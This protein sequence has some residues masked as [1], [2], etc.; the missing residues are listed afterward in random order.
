[1]RLRD[2][3]PVP[4]YYPLVTVAMQRI[5]L[6]ARGLHSNLP[7]RVLAFRACSRC[8]NGG[9]NL[10]RHASGLAEHWTIGMVDLPDSPVRPEDSQRP[11]SLLWR[12][13]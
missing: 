9:G 10:H 11:G 2:H 4:P 6:E 8:V 7:T 1:M 12:F 13:V 5:P 3:M